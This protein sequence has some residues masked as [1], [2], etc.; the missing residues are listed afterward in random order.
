MPNEYNQYF[1][2]L[3]TALRAAEIEQKKRYDSAID[4]ED[5]AE[6]TAV[7]ID[8]RTKIQ[9]LRKWIEDLQRINHEVETAF[10]AAP[11]ASQEP[12]DAI[13]AV[14]PQLAETA[15]QRNDEDY[16][17]LQNIGEYVRQKMYALCRGGYI[18]TDA[19]LHDMQDYGWSRNV[20]NL[21][22]PFVR[23]YD[24][25]QDL[26]EQTSINGVPRRYCVKDRFRFGDV[27]LLIYSGWAPLYKP[28][29]D[30]W[31]NSLTET[32]PAEDEPFPVETKPEHEEP[33]IGI[34]VRGKLRE[35]CNSGYRPSLGDIGEFQ[36]KRWS[37]ETL[38]LNYPFTGVYNTSIP[39][40]AQ[41]STDNGANRFWAEIFDFGNC[42]LLFCSQWY[43]GDRAY[44][45]RWYDGLVIPHQDDACNDEP[46]AVQS[47]SDISDIAT[48]ENPDVAELRPLA[49]SEEP[50]SEESVI[51]ANEATAVTESIKGFSLLGK[52][53]TASN[54]QEL[55]AKLCEAMVLKKPYKFASLGADVCANL[56]GRPIL[57]LDEQLTEPHQ[58]LSN[59]L[60]VVT[61]G[62]DN[63]IK[64]RC[65]H[66]LSACGYSNDVLQIL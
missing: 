35:L 17:S 30:A 44:F 38:N 21:P 4:I 56:L 18:F 48:D 11:S 23:I 12:A 62:S 9:Q 46:E 53:Y 65:E 32:L 22:H 63:E 10:P 34:Y 25:G 58:K 14:V 39:L 8:A 28:F 52:S 24:E 61:G 19:Q 36:Q 15:V 26:L 2:G 64:T 20:L 37:K 41:L 27:T 57:S 51:V 47:T 13:V 33:K 3:L 7:T 29:F 16:S 59:G 54:W 60:Y 49:T 40:R 42:Q 43:E 66:I 55:L 6:A 1:S 31:Y 45:D 50:D 5:M